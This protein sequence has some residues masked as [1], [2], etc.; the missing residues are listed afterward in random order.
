[1]RQTLSRGMV[2]AAA[3]T[4]ILALC[5]SPALADYVSGGTASA[6]PGAT[7]GTHRTAPD[8]SGH[9]ETSSGSSV[10]G[11]CD[12]AFDALAMGAG[13]FGQRCDDEGGYIDKSGYGDNGAENSSGGGYGDEDSDGGYG[14]T[15]SSPPQTT[16]PPHT[17]PPHTKPPHTKPPHTTHP[18]TTHPPHTKPPH[19]K[20]PHTH[21]PHTKPPHT[22]PPHTKPPHTTHPPTT[23]PPHTTQPPTQPPHTG[24]TKP[25]GHPGGPPHMPDTGS[26]KALIAASG[27]SAALI[28][29]GALLFRR[30]RRT[31]SHR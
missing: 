16:S 30:G 24:G 1:M 20:P 28:A 18:P 25:P 23:H 7:S 12:E 19:T 27:V 17:K 26:G 13:P 6:S 11:L 21:P 22:K 2:A 4:S 8:D 31:G 5:G 9:G 29:A 10:S 14:D 15:P 3:A